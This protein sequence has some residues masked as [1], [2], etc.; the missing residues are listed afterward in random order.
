MRL[1][2][3]VLAPLTHLQRPQRTFLGQLLRRLLRLPGP[4]PVRHGRRDRSAHEP[5]WARP[6]APSVDVV[7]RQPAALM[8]VV[9][10]AHAQ[11]RVCE[12][13]R[14]PPRGQHPAGRARGWTGPQRHPAHG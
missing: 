14:I 5:T 3:R 12:A 8:P 10:P 1:F 4:A 11:A 9:P 6:G 7:A 13:R 2:A